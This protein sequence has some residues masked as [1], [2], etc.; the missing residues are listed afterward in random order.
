VLEGTGTDLED[1]PLTD[2]TAFTW[3]SSLEGELGVGRRLYFD[4]LLPGQHTVTLT[5]R[6]SDGFTVQESI[7]ILIGS[8][9]YLPL[10]LKAYQ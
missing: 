4:D 7:S 10:T 6:D 8:R 9:V 5:V 1:G 3:S 2:D